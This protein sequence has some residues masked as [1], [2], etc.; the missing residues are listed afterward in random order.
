MLHVGV[1]GWRIATC[2]NAF[3]QN[4]TLDK[5]GANA[6]TAGLPLATP[7]TPTWP[8]ALAPQQNG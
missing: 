2:Q 5:L 7:A 6:R 8:L 4:D 1:A 3:I